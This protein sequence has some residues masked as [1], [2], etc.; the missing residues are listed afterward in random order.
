MIHPFTV[1]IR[2]NLREGETANVRYLTRVGYPYYGPPNASRFGKKAVVFTGG[3][4]D[5]MRAYK[6]APEG[7]FDRAGVTADYLEDHPEE[8]DNPRRLR[9]I[10]ACLREMFVWRKCANDLGY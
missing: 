2:G 6:A 9:L 4:A 3:A 5:I 1:Y 10:V 8:C 7:D